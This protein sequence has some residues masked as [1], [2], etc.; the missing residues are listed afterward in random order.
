MATLALGY[1]TCIK[2]L[3][4]ALSLQGKP[5]LVLSFKSQ[6]LLNARKRIP[7]KIRKDSTTL[8]QR[9]GSGKDELTS[10]ELTRSHETM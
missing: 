6:T 7:R 9:A 10:S 3:R 4:P 1:S 2:L 5:V 8:C